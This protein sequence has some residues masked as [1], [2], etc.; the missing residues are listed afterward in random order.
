MGLLAAAIEAGADHW[1]ELC[2][3]LEVLDEETRAEANVILT[4]E[5]WTAK[6]AG[7]T[8]RTIGFRGDGATVYNHQRAVNRG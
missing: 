3:W 8:F 7:A 5:S 2:E 6:K 1:C 4:D